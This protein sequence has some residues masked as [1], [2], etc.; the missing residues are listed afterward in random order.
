MAPEVLASD[1]AEA[2]VSG[3]LGNHQIVPA[4]IAPL[5]IG[6]S[7]SDCCFI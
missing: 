1:T 4:E 6:K 3:L 2:I 7:A 5:V